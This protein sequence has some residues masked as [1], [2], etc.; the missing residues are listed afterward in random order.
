MATTWEPVRSNTKTRFQLANQQG[1][2]V[3]KRGGFAVLWDIGR[4][5]ID[6]D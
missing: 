2:T 3:Y 6:M 5:M 4:K 1:R